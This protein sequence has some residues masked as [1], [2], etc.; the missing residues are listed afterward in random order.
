M[1]TRKRLG[2]VGE[3]RGVTAAPSISVIAEVELVAG[4]HAERLEHR[5]AGRAAGPGL[6]DEHRLR[7]EARPPPHGPATRRSTRRHRPR[8]R[9]RRRMCRRRPRAGRTL[10]RSSGSSSWYDQSTV[11]RSVCWRSTRPRRLPVRMRNRSSSCA[12]IS[13][14]DIASTRAAASSM[15]S[16]MPSTRRQISPTACRLSSVHAAVG[17]GVARAIGEHARPRVSVACE[18]RHRARPARRATLERLAAG[19]Q[20]RDVRTRP[21]DRVGEVA[22]VVEEVLAVVE[23]EEQL[24]HLEELDDAVGQRQPGA[25]LAAERRAMTCAIASSSSAAASSQNH[26][27]SAKSGQHLGRDLDREAGLAHAARC[28]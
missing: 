1:P 18:R 12:A 15:A 5:V 13:T 28:R 19:R 8:A 14:A 2:I 23:H 21:H 20:H 17:A 3:V 11:A 24:P 9:P 16:G 10:V 22:G 27:P 6:G 25:L 26:A 4:E 7:H